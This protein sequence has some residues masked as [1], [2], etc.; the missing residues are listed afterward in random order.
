VL[1]AQ[2]AQHQ[3]HG[4]F[5][6]V[7]HRLAIVLLV[8]GIDQRIQGKRVVIRRGDVFFDERAQH[9]GFSGIQDNIHSN[10]LSGEG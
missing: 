10:N 1:V 9:T 3:P 2:V 7:R 5:V 4:F 6:K 8:A